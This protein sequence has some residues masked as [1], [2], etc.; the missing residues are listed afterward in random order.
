MNKMWYIPIQGKHYSAIK[1][2]KVLNSGP[3]QALDPRVVSSSP[4]LGT[5]PT[6]RALAARL[7]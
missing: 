6:Y 4:M 5:D 1:R 7:E 3:W 2:S